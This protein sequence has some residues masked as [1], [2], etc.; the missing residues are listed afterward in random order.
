MLGGFLLLLGGQILMWAFFFFFTC[1]TDRLFTQ[2]IRFYDWIKQMPCWGLDLFF[3]SGELSLRR[4][5][6]LIFFSPAQTPFLKAFESSNSSPGSLILIWIQLIECFFF[7]PA[8]S[9]FPSLPSTPV[10]TFANFPRNQ[11]PA[12][13]LPT[14]SVCIVP[15]KKT[16]HT[17]L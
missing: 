10:K 8:L 12:V 15:P 13:W 4:F 3:C 2:S 11:I 7:R 14:S 6:G 17:T 1:P 5:I 9:Q 16:N